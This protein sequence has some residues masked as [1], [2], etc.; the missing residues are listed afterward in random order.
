MN[1]DKI[2]NE[3]SLH[4]EPTEPIAISD[5]EKYALELLNLHLRSIKDRI[6]DILELEKEVKD[7]LSA[8]DSIKWNQECPVCK[9]IESFIKRYKLFVNILMEQVSARQEKIA[10]LKDKNATL[11][12]EQVE[13]KKKAYRDKLTW[14]YN[15]IVMD[16]VI[17]YN[18]SEA[19]KRKYNFSLAILD[20]DNFKSVNDAF[21]HK[22]WDE[23]LKS[24]AKFIENSIQTL[25]RSKFV[26][27]NYNRKAWEPTLAF[28]Y[29]WEEFIILSIISQNELK[30][31]LDLCLL[32]F[33]KIVH[34]FWEINFTITFSW[35]ITEFIGGWVDTR[36]EHDLVH[37]ADLLLY[38][39]KRAWRCKIFIDDDIEEK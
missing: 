17:N 2:H 31:F 21:G 4:F 23:V 16:N 8:I 27:S 39:A 6:K 25:N 18:I 20:I 36:N 28:R 12:D 5:E 10:F 14:L 9:D 38:K 34:S 32:R 24:F 15:R 13:L 7:M 22:I 33:S 11:T 3:D 35:W 1:E 26:S 30:K 19:I 29:W 37:S